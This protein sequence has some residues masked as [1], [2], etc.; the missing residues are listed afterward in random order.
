MTGRGTVVLDSRD[1][2]GRVT[3]R[4]ELGAVL[5]DGRILS[6]ATATQDQ[7]GQWLVWFVTRAQ[8]S[9]AFDAMALTEY[10]HQVGVVL[11]D[12]VVSAPRINA[13]S[14]HG[15]GEITGDF[16]A[17]QAKTLAAILNTPG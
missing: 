6:H 11:G 17:G 5:L 3:A 12:L 8:G 2:S 14:F 4:Y 16:S 13:T 9:R 10:Q 15:S 1:S 7:A